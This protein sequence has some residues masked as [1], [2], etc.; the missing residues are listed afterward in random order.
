MRGR[1]PQS[2]SAQPYERLLA[3]IA[4]A[5]PSR[6]SRALRAINDATPGLDEARNYFAAIPEDQLAACWVAVV[7]EGATRDDWTLGDLTRALLVVATR[8]HGVTWPDGAPELAMTGN[9]LATLA[10]SRTTDQEAA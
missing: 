2:S 6:G 9:M 1:R 4:H 5:S 3:S 7:V 8:L 10:A